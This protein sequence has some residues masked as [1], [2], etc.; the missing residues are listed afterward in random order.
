MVTIS[1]CG[2]YNV[3]VLFVCVYV[4][5]SVAASHCD[6]I[7]LLLPVSS[8]TRTVSNL[9]NETKHDTTSTGPAQVLCVL[10][11]HRQKI[12]MGGGEEFLNG[13]PLTN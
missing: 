10:A 1:F 3:P 2:V 7:L 6:H 8:Q 13:D 5:G 9:E 11:L 12:V 4:S